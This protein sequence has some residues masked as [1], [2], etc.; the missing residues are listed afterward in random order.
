MWTDLSIGEILPKPTL[1]HNS[2]RGLCPPR[3][4]DF[5]VN[6]F[7]LGRQGN[8]CATEWPQEHG[9]ISHGL[10][11]WFC[12]GENGLAFFGWLNVTGVP[13]ES[14]LPVCGDGQ[15]EPEWD[16]PKAGQE[17]LHWRILLWAQSP[18]DWW[19]QGSFQDKMI[20][21]IQKWMEWSACWFLKFTF[22]KIWFYLVSAGKATTV[23]TKSPVK[24]Q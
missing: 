24:W 2:S 19:W 5:S 8:I 7:K 15:G 16:A 12:P 23:I 6:Y 13:G 17:L 18:G 20:E 10:S 9:Q 1:S 14:F 4:F 21:R 22:V 11:Q 3:I